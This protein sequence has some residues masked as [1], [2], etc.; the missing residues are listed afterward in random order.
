MK[1]EYL[2]KWVDYYNDLEIVFPSNEKEIKQAHKRLSKKYHPDINKGNEEK[3]KK[4]QNAYEVLINPKRKKEYDFYYKMQ[5]PKEKTDTNNNQTKTNTF[6]KHIIDL[7]KESSTLEELANIWKYID[8]KFKN[9]FQKRTYYVQ[10][11]K[12]KLPSVEF[13][14]PFFYKE[15]IDYDYDYDQE[16]SDEKLQLY[17]YKIQCIYELYNNVSLHNII[18]LNTET[19]INKE[20]YFQEML[21]YALTMMQDLVAS[22]YITDQQTI[23]TFYNT[24]LS[25]GYFMAQTNNQAKMY[26]IS[27]NLP[28]QNNQNL[29][30][31]L[32][33]FQNKLRKIEAILDWNHTVFYEEIVEALENNS[34]LHYAIAFDTFK[35]IPKDYIKFRKDAKRIL[36]DVKIELK[37]MPFNLYEYTLLNQLLL[38]LDDYKER[39]QLNCAIYA[40]ITALDN[41]NLQSNLDDYHHEFYESLFDISLETLEEDTQESIQQLY[42]VYSSCYSKETIEAFQFN[43]RNIK[44]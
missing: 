7:I 17:F 14:N 9:G 42:A 2:K 20:L 24:M 40:L 18:D 33:S 25:F 5:M 34:P 12:E 1:E 44:K 29:N 28:K 27:Q 15:H 22:Y 10:L 11:I 31:L 30:Y 4:A 37:K 35:H 21:K 41:E 43:T 16:R 32:T 19:H 3:F 23:D 13:V 26:F 39:K 8:K 36:Y 38:K 6:Q